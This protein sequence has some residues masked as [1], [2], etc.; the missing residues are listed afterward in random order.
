MQTKQ[1]KGFKAVFMRELHRIATHPIYLFMLFII[2]AGCYIFFSTL[3]PE[4]L[5][6]KLPMG[7]IDHD[8]SIV[9][10][11]II[12]QIDATAQSKITGHYLNFQEARADMQL[13][14]IYGFVEIPANFEKDVLLNKQPKLWY[15]Y[16]QA[17]YIPGSLTLKNLGTMLN[18]LSGAV[19]LQARQARG[20]N[21]KQS[22][23]LIQPIVPDIHLIGN[24]YINY[25]VYLLD[26][27][28]P[29][30]LELIVLLTSVYIIGI[31]L[32]KETSRDW[33]KKSGN[34]LVTA[35]TGKFLPYTIAFSIMG[36][37]YNIILF[38]FLNYPLNTNILW[39]FLNTI[40]MI[41]AAQSVGILMIG[42]SPVLRNALSFASLY[43]VLAFSF[44]GFS[45]PIEG[46]L[47]AVQ[48]LSNIFPL[49]FYF[50]IYQNAALN[51]LDSQYFILN[52]LLLLL[53][54]LLPLLIGNR[55][56]KALIY[57]NYPKK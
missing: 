11:K 57:L 48:G 50:K 15:Y 27:I 52:Y 33:L 22:L 24:P 10:R 34:S 43:G 21:E 39:M 46:M 36:I 19:N 20:Q 51:G 53:F 42:I 23:A 3:M 9:S 49:R 37:F 6:E 44:S 45:F 13:G 16:N 41:L 5:P 8:N 7:V 18:T 31:E 25:S 56:K 4:G 32:K 28:I 29:G 35:L 38:K 17:Y 30:I 55:L 26:I 1:E 2:P 12:R 40:F 54:T 14:N 47:P